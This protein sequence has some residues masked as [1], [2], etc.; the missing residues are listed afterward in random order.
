MAQALVDIGQRDR[1][2]GGSSLTVSFLSSALDKGIFMLDHFWSVR[3]CLH[4]SPEWT[5]TG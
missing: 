4:I 3:V 5:H 2:G 1:A